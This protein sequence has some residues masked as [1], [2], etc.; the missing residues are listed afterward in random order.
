MKKFKESELVNLMDS[1]F[2][3]IPMPKKNEINEQNE[4]DDQFYPHWKNEIYMN[5]VFDSTPY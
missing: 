2:G 5:L 1:T 3:D 4:D